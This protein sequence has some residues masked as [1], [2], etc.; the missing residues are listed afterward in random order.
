MRAQQAGQ[1]YDEST[2]NQFLNDLQQFNFMEGLAPP[3]VVPPAASDGEWKRA[4]TVL[5][6]A[7]KGEKIPAAI[8][9][10]G[11]VLG[12]TRWPRGTLLRAARKTENRI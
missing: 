11:S 9:D 2:F 3:L 1:K 5:L 8:D 4:G 12:A 6:E 7:A 10:Y